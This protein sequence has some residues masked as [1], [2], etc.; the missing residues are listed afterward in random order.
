MSLALCLIACLQE[1]AAQESGLPPVESLRYAGER[2][3]GAIRRLTTDGENA[4]GY[5]S[6]DGTRITYQARVGDMECDQ[7]FD[8]DLLTGG[9]R[10][11]STGKG[12][13]TCSYFLGGGE[14]VL[15]AST[16][17]AADGC[18]EPADFS[19]GYVWKVYSQFDLWVRDL[20]T[21]ELK[22]LAHAPGYD[23]EAVVSPDG[24][25]IAFTSMR[26]GDLDV[27]IMN[28]DGSDL[29]QLTRDVGYDGGAFFSPDSKRL[30]FRAHHPNTDETVADYKRLLAQDLIRPTTLEIW[31]MDADGGNKRQVTDN[32]AANFAP[33]F[34]PDGRRL[35]YSSNQD[36]GGRNF[37]L[38]II[39][40]D[41]TGNERV[42]HCPLFDGFPMFSPDGKRLIFASN[43]AAADPR[44][45]NLFIAEWVEPALAE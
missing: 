37:D 27:W 26:G 4:E 14:A 22:P 15:F 34:H 8:L 3:F 38:W 6:P 39:R 2:Y 23:A 1:P 21:W 36:G 11:I 33:F 24:K 45:T 43:R 18:L 42:T 28:A 17:G 29:K 32:G 12:R 31:V 9:R 35:L 16:H 30:V 44:S 41:G 10:L 7:I 19:Q 40:D 5:F 25:K 20:R 13:T